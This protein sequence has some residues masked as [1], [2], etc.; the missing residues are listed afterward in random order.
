MKNILI[1]GVS[2]GLG[3][4]L[5]KAYL[6]NG[7]N[8]Y[9]IGKD[10][11][12][13]FDHYPHFFFFPYDLNETFTLRANIK[14]FVEKHSFDIV[15]LNADIQ[16]KIQ[17]LNNTNL[18]D[19]KEVMEVNLWANKELI[20]A[21]SIY[22]HASQIVGISAGA[23]VNGSK[24]WGSYSISKAALNM[25]FSVYAKELPEIHF[26]AL[27]PGVID[28]Q[29]V[30]QIIENVDDSVFPSVKQLR[31]SNILT[32]QEAAKI[33]IDIFPKLLSYESGS[34]LDIRTID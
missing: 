21:L 4:A 2:S 27:A 22:S 18:V 32:P 33:L 10:L 29:M 23:P 25:L 24:G 28:A 20:D 31:E 7:D 9:A 14:D 15:I 19:A 5:V 3:E 8:V 34:F 26:A 1:T 13:K 6:E 16:G 17:E 12:K 11:P 30:H